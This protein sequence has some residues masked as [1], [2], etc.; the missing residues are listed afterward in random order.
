M[1]T[2]TRRPNRRQLNPKGDPMSP[3]M[4]VDLSLLLVTAA[5]SAVGLAMIYST[6]R[7]TDPTGY[8]TTFVERQVMFLMVG[9]AALA[10]IAIMPT[11]QLRSWAPIVYG[12]GVVLLLAVLSPLGVERNGAQA[13]FEFASFQLQPSEP[14]KVAYVL[15][16]ASY[17][18]RFNGDL[19]MVQLGG[20]L[21]IGA[22]PL[23]LIM[24][25]PDVGTAAVFVAITMGVLLIGGAR[26]RHIV[27]L[28]IFGLLCVVVIWNAGLL[29]GYQQDR[30]RS[31]LDPASSQSVTAYQQTQAQIAIGSGGV[32]GQGFGQGRQTRGEFV[33]EQHTDFIFTV[34]GEELGFVGATA[35]V[36]LFAFLIWRCWRSAVKA[37][38]LFGSL[39]CV[40]VLTMLV[41]QMFQA[42]GMTLGIMPITGIP[43]PFMSYGG[44]S[45][46]TSLAAIGL[47]LN[48]H[49]HRH[50]RR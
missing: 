19:T 35:V 50:T 37:A 2:T 13:W 7:G 8:D 12:G 32:T 18:A 4:H 1:V 11:P 49:M 33:P 41:F 9:T 29:K 27:F 47:V 6:T 24:M 20:A 44:S 14:L 36:G 3:W 34:V 5:L 28:T 39:L 46:L 26:V 25:Q 48:V 15:A 22:L 21:L 43:V 30:L 38:D 16:L 45:A 23:G 42:I 10:A 40:G 17:V 31:F